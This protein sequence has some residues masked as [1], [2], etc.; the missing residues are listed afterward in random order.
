[1]YVSCPDLIFARPLKGR[2]QTRDYGFR[3]R[4]L[5]F[6]ASCFLSIQSP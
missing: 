2:S 3:Q 6:N 1:M 4:T 5:P